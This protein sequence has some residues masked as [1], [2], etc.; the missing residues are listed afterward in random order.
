[1]QLVSLQLLPS[2][3]A[4]P[5]NRLVVVKTMFGEKSSLRVVGVGGV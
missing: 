3:Q 1:M 2:G 4:M 5:L